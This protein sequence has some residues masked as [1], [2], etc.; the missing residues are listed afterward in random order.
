MLQGYSDKRQFR[1]L[2][3]K[4]PPTWQLG[5]ASSPRTPEKE[6]GSLAKQIGQPLWLTIEGRQCDVW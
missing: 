6:E 1:V 5:A 2:R 3:R 4:V